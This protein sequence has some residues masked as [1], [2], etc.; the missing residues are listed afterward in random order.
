M[1]V[2][3]AIRKFGRPAVLV[4]VTLI[5]SGVVFWIVT[6]GFTL[7][8]VEVVG[9]G[10]Y[11]AIDSQKLPKN[12]LLLST[13]KLQ[14]SL[15]EQY[16]LLLKAQ[17]SKRYPHTLVITAVARKPIARIATTLGTF[18]LD[19]DGVVVDEK[20]SSDGLPLLDIPVQTITIGS[21]LSDPAVM[22]TLGLLQKIHP[23]V[24]IEN[25]VMNDSTSLIAKTST[26]DILF[27]HN[28]DTQ[29]IATTLQTLFEGFRIKGTL[30]TRIDLRF[31]KPVV[32]F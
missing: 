28:A 13:G 29:A 31:D 23:V 26:T 12:L 2:M 3:V 7:T 16:P 6:S 19:P 27:T 18:F 24:K 20:K 10:V 11:L 22:T 14:A 1:S 9:D 21:K 25:I 30:P 4:F 32:I 15:I 5:A 17:V 8:K